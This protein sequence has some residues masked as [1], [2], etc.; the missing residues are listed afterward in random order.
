MKR[1]SI[2]VILV[3]VLIAGWA[4]LR[5]GGPKE[6]SYQGRTLSQWIR[7]KE[8]AN[9][10]H[11]ALVEMGTNTVP[12]LVQW[13]KTTDS[14]IKIRLNRLLGKQKFFHFRFQTADDTRF[15]AYKG[16]TI[17]RHDAIRAIPDL[18]RLTASHDPGQAA[19]S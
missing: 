10:I 2:I 11:H 19:V 7:S 16:F 6:P 13:L 9:E 5:S 15:I 18:I 1:L 14:T 3:A 8:G 12:I 4:A 17:L